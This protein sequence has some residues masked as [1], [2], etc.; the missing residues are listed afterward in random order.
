MQL[1]SLKALRSAAAR[2]IPNENL[3]NGYNNNNNNNTVYFLVFKCHIKIYEKE[4][5]KKNISLESLCVILKIQ[6]KIKIDD[7]DVCKNSSAK[8]IS[9][10]K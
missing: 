1:T 5:D 9:N 7:I 8:K 2:V 10:R 3:K 4:N 6:S